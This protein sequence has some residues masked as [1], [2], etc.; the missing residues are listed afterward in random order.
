MTK[1]QR[2]CIESTFKNFRLICQTPANSINLG[3]ISNDELVM[4]LLDESYAVLD[5]HY[6]LMAEIDKCHEV[7]K[8]FKAEY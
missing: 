3:T 2:E 8:S 5:K 1:Q 6:E 7:I 4:A